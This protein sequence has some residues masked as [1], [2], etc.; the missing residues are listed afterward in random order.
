MFH[1]HSSP[2]ETDPVSHPA[3]RVLAVLVELGGLEQA[4][5]CHISESAGSV[6]VLS[7]PAIGLK[8]VAV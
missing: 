3:I 4:V 7:P 6:A 1:V 8:G 5:L 2:L